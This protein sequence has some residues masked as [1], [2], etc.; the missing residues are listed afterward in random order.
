MRKKRRRLSLEIFGESFRDG[1]RRVLAAGARRLLRADDTCE[2]LDV[3]TSGIFHRGEDSSSEIWRYIRDRR[4]LEIRMLPSPAASSRYSVTRNPPS[5]TLA[6][7]TRLRPTDHLP[8]PQFCVRAAATLR[9]RYLIRKLIRDL[10]RDLLRDRIRDIF[11]ERIRDLIRH[12][13]RHRIRHRIRHLIRHR[14]GS[15]T[16]GPPH[17]STASS[18]GGFRSASTRVLSYGAASAH[19]PFTSRAA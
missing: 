17:G 6:V 7:W 9:L 16:T 13:I 10:V 11:R 18:A 4:W 8:L 14:I 2:R 3:I 12:L 19:L 1:S 5:L 15:P